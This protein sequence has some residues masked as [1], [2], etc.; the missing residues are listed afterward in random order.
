M[1][2]RGRE[3]GSKRTGMR[4]TK[5]EDCYIFLGIY[6]E[7]LPDPV[8]VETFSCVLHVCGGFFLIQFLLLKKTFTGGWKGVKEGFLK[9]AE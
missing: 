8:S 1:T 7:I 4:E 6:R 9:E 5:G 2:K 3:K